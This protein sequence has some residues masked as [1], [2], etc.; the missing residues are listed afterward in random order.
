LNLLRIRLMLFQKLNTATRRNGGALGDHQGTVIRARS[1]SWS[2]A[3]A[4]GG[5]GKSLLTAHLAAD[6]ADRG[7]QVLAAD[8]DWDGGNLQTLLGGSPGS[9]TVTDIAEDG[10]PDTPSALPMVRTGLRLLPGVSGFFDA[11]TAAARVELLS[12]LQCMPCHHLVMDLG[13][14]PQDHVTAPFLGADVPLLVVVPDPVGVENAY[15]FLGGLVRE[16]VREAID[17][18]TDA[19]PRRWESLRQVRSLEELQ[20]LAAELDGDAL[21]LADR[22]G[23]EL[24]G[25][26][27]YLVLNQVRRL[28]DLEV[29][30]GL[31]QVARSTFGCELRTMGAIQYDER[32]WIALRKGQAVSEWGPTEGLGDD[33]KELVDALLMELGISAENRSGGVALVGQHCSADVAGSR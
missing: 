33:L 6:L 12:V 21:A 24:A 8:L 17:S 22:V 29:A 25:R 30:N 11:P 23:A 1:V 14:G 3:G 16:R 31:E 27:I 4:R 10:A 2:V 18:A 13:S 32:V 5:T 20:R 9:L 19:P 28:D 26:P 7:W 15:R